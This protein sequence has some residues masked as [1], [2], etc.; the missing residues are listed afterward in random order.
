MYGAEAAKKSLSGSLVAPDHTSAA[1]TARAINGNP[2]PPLIGNTMSEQGFPVRNHITQ[3]VHILP[4]SFFAQFCIVMI[5]DFLEQ[6]VILFGSADP[7]VCMFQFL[8]WH[9]ETIMLN[10]PEKRVP[11][12]LVL[13]LCPLP[14]PPALRRFRFYSDLITFVRPFLQVV[15]PV[16]E[17]YMLTSSTVPNGEGGAEGQG[18]AY[19]EPTRFEVVHFQRYEECFS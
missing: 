12:L 15:P 19:N 5:A 8:R 6:G 7:D 13:S 4:A 9:E 2:Y 16:W 14:A 10:T 3:S 17:K 11:F 18:R 1:D